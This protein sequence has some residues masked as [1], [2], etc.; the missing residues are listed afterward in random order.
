MKKEAVIEGKKM[1]RRGSLVKKVRVSAD[2]SGAIS[3]PPLSTS[4]S[5]GELQE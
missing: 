3:S 2:S 5:E 1:E 4:S